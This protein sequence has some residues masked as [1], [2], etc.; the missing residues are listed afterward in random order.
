VVA[1]HRV[2]VVGPGSI[3]LL[4]TYHLHRAGADYILVAR[5]AERARLL[6][7]MGVR[8]RNGG[9]T[10]SFTPRV[11][12]PEELSGIVDVVLLT[13]KS[14]DVSRALGVVEKLM[15]PDTICV[16]VQNGFGA[17]EALAKR[18]GE[19]RVAVGLVT[20]GAYRVG[21]NEVVIPSGEGEIM[22]GGSDRAGLEDVAELLRSSG[23]RARVVENVEGWRWL[24]TLINAGI[25][26]LTALLR[27]R[28]GELLK[29]PELLAVARTAVE[30]GAEVARR[31]G[32]ELPRDPVEALIEVLRA[33]SGNKSSMLQDLE[34]CR[35]TEIDY[36]NGFIASK[37]RELGLEAPVNEVLT[38][39]VK[40]ASRVCSP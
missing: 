4:L 20:Y 30:E 34:A 27:V 14:Y 1:R 10:H 22:L 2:A 39:L 26:P 36:I 37:A 13:V 18:F 17:F 16:S 21:I 38:A 32:V 3:G 15:G 25:N 19:S 31:L 6:R 40:V 29:H 33:T 28:N 12:S 5:S 24:K 23:L 35:E 7:I 9:Y 8:V 11:F